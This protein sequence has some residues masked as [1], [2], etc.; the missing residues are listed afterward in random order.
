MGFSQA[1][2]EISSNA[3]ANGGFGLIITNLQEGLHVLRISSPSNTIHPWNNNKRKN[4]KALF[5]YLLD[6]GPLFQETEF[7]DLRML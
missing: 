6:D 5:V 4:I 1:K 2:E 3:Y 7:K